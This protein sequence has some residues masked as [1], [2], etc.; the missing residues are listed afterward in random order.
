[1]KH[2][3]RWT[4]RSLLKSGVAAIAAAGVFP[5]TGYVGSAT[6]D[7]ARFLFLTDT[8]LDMKCSAPNLAYI[9]RWITDNAEALNIRYVAHHG[10]VGDRRGT[11]SIGE[12]L[13]ASR[14]ALQPVMDAGI[15]FSVAIGNHDYD[16]ASDTRPCE[17]FNDAEAFGQSFYD[18]Q[19][20]LGGTFEGEA[21]KPGADP[22]G[23]ANHYMTQEIA[24][25]PFL[26]LVLELFPRDKVMAWADDLVKKQFPE[27]EVVVTTHAYVHREGHLCT[28]VGYDGFSREEGPEY[29]NDGEEMW[30]K[31]FKTWPNLRLISGGH[32][33]DEPRQNYLE[34]TGDAGNT[35]HSHF[36]NY[37]NWGYSDGE[38]FNT[39]RE[40]ENQ[41]AMVK[42]FEVCFNENEVYIENVIP[43]A[44]VEGEPAD[45]AH[46]NTW[47]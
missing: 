27:H 32:F 35:V 18:G 29:S 41:A 9:A 36:W 37:Q 1:M 28:G 26:F 24:G 43:P 33:I 4:R 23:T 20:W 47:G 8:H 11:G 7:R 39:R 31:Y 22:G 21:A 14:D 38:L 42:M 17:A 2:D 6:D 19:P 13:K 12:M 16:V 15:P 10:D 34:Q 3:K 45:P 44:G 30:E 46:H 40:G 5:L 25:H